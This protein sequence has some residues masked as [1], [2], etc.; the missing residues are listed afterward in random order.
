MVYP[1]TGTLKKRGVGD[2]LLLRVGRIQID[3]LLRGGRRNK[4]NRRDGTNIKSANIIF[5]AHIKATEGRD[6]PA[7]IPSDIGGG[8]MGA[9][10]VASSCDEDGTW[11]N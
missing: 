11:S 3:E 7:A 8:N 2:P 1:S 4:G 9:Y 6:F 5:A 10:Y